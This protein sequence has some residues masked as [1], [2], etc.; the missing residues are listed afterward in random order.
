MI[1]C[2][3]SA[4]ENAP[5]AGWCSFCRAVGELLGA[6]LHAFNGCASEKLWTL[7]WRSYETRIERIQILILRGWFCAQWGAHWASSSLPLPPRLRLTSLVCIRPFPP[8]WSTV[9]S[10]H[11]RMLSRRGDALFVGQWES[12]SEL[13][14]TPSTDAPVKSYGHFCQSYKTR[15]QSI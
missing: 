1:N 2:H 8:K 3:I 12:F 6:F 5:E 13:F 11:W 15:L 14:C 9:I 7:F 4:L 10:R